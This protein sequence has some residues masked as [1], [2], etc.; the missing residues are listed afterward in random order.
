MDIFYFKSLRISYAKSFNWKKDV[1]YENLS[2]EWQ[3]FLEHFLVSKKNFEKKFALVLKLLQNPD[4]LFSEDLYSILSFKEM[5]FFVNFLNSQNISFFCVTNQI[6][7]TPFF[8]Y[9][10][11][12]KNNRIALEGRTISVLK[13][14]KIM[15]L[16]GYSLPFYVNMSI[17]LGYYGI[18]DDIYLSK[19]ELEEAIWPS[20]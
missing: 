18:V 20:K 19:E 11:V 9:L 14:E 6:E 3:Q 2:L 12:I 1:N 13:E 16:L 4:F 17:Q 7:N 15:K 5:G 10:L 8:D